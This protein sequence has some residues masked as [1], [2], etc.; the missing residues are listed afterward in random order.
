MSSGNQRYINTAGTHNITMGD[1]FINVSTSVGA[2]TLVFP[3]IRDSGAIN[4]NK[5]WF[6]NDVDD[7]AETN[8]VT[9]VAS[10]TSPVTELN[11]GS[12]VV[13]NTNGFSAEVVPSGYY[14]YMINAGTG[15]GGM[16]GSGTT[17][18][19]AKWTPDGS[20][21]GNSQIFDN[22]TNVGIGTPD[23]LARLSLNASDG[24]SFSMYHAAAEVISAQLLHQNAVGATF[25]LFDN[26]GNRKIVFSAKSNDSYINTG[27]NF[28]VGITTPS[29]RVHVQGSDATSGNYAL[30]VDN[31]A[32]SP[33]L[34]V[35]NDGNV[36]IGVPSAP[37]Y[38][39]EVIG[40]NNSTITL[41]GDLS[42][43]IATA[44]I[45]SRALY[46]TTS[47]HDLGLIT[48]ATERLTILSTG[49]VG[50]GTNAPTAGTRLHVYR[51]VNDFLY[52]VK[53]ENPTNG[54]SA[55]S[56]IL[57][58][59]DAGKL[60]FGQLST[61]FTAFTAYGQTGDTFVR[62]GSGARNLNF[63][64]DASNVGKILFFSRLNPTSDATIPSLC[65]DGV[66][67]SIGTNSATAYFQI[68]GAFGYN[69]L[70]METT[71]TPTDSA[72]ANGSVGDLSWDDN[73]IYMKVSTGWKRATLS[74]F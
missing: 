27:A 47:A 19:V 57:I 63:V 1:D 62:S 16:S 5:V 67:V 4:S 70:R 38:K 73:Y 69:Q 12:S 17:N 13:L 65:V 42:T 53:V 49:N 2:I 55:A 35:R 50:I 60:E 43:S 3:N 20:T 44:I 6:V 58:Q 11:G 48:G 66:K 26:T 61:L 30:K 29:S 39:L 37:N 56:A 31:S 7:M 9:I 10:A 28:G 59:S 51:A 72:D 54:V 64:T 23:P 24:Q 22:G 68:K 25:T 32:S 8:N 71:Y 18:Y 74:A 45:G 14:S 33:L 40:S 52:E 46:G 36:G 21:L 34:Y 41:V 15:G